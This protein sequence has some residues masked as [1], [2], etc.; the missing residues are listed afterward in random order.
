MSTLQNDLT[1]E[2]ARALCIQFAFIK[3]KNFFL[4]E[5]NILS[6][7]SELG[8]QK[9][10]FLLKMTFN[11]VFFQLRKEGSRKAGIRKNWEKNP[12]QIILSY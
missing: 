12:D 6:Q 5:G 8:I 11:L 3:K 7:M 1:L 9:S 2:D 10:N 4:R